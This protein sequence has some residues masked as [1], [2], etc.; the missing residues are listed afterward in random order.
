MRVLGCACVC[1]GGWVGGPP[2]AP[3][4]GGCRRPPSPF[5]GRG[6]VLVCPPR[7]WAALGCRLPLLGVQAVG[8]L[9]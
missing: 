5:A 8:G 9:F 7:W 6:L 3:P 4:G 2:P 1:S